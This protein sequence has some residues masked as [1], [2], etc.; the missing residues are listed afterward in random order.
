MAIL[1]IH[2]LTH[3]STAALAVEG[4]LA[5]FFQEERL[6]RIKG[7]G[8][9]PSRS[10]RACLDVAGLAPEDIES[11]V[12]PFRPWIGA[13]RRLAYQLR[14]PNRGLRAA[15]QLLT[16][17]R[18]NLGLRVQ[19][20]EL[21]IRAPLIRCDHH[22]AHARAV[23]LAS[24]FD[25]AAILVVDGVAEAW[26]GATFH[27]R[28]FPTPEF[29]CLRRFRFPAS[30]GLVYAAVTEHLGF[31]HNREEGKVMAM[32]AFGD[33]SQIK[34]FARICR[35][36]SG[37]ISVE[38]S[39][40]DFGGRWTTS[41]FWKLFGEARHPEQELQAR[42]FALARALQNTIERCCTELASTLLG[43]TGEQHLCFTGG[44][45]LNPAINA[46]LS[47]AT[48]PTRCYFLPAGGDAGTALGAALAI[49]PDPQWRLKHP[50]WGGQATRTEIEREIRRAGLVVA[51]QGDTAFE[52]SAE[53]LAQGAIGAL[54]S[55]R[56]EMGPRALGHR[57]ILAD[58]SRVEIR[59]RL[60]AQIKK[61][62]AFQPFG[63]CV[64]STIS[65]EI[66][67]GLGSSPF[68]L[69]TAAVSERYRDAIPA[70]VHADGTS[71]PQTI[72][73][74][75]DSELASLLR[76]FE[77]SGRLP[78]LLNTSLNLRGEPLA[79]TV[80]D[81]IRVFLKGHLDFLLIEDRLIER[82]RNAE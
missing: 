56:S 36:E 17:G 82:A 49:D 12:L 63:P 4:R 15:T 2:A 25:T 80:E 30:L 18:Q 16:R 58:S 81:A 32:A 24:P 9:F 21:G 6:S 76:A 67:P 28:R 7:D 46:A 50:F 66:F 68:M 8:A 65:D 60:N 53:L 11:V 45:A 51:C 54:F 26:S 59:D 14:H 71:R 23:F 37:R 20:K 22:E 77:A 42:H 70:V 31:R 35:I 47:H 79:E 3:D 10:I 78:I 34:A 13:G 75:D 29:N 69:K 73:A 43:L 62:E 44:M 39:C 19:L 72:S 52:R 38:D 27:A 74:E 33:E 61:R 64:S 57:S 55:G 40:F 1:G 48:A 41:R 5:A